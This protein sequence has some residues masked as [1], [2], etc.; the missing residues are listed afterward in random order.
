MES[1]SLAFLQALEALSPTQRAVL[2]LT[3]VFD[4]SSAEV[5]AA[6]E[7]SVS[8][9]RTIHHRAKRAM[10][11]YDKQRTIPTTDRRRATAAALE[12]FLQLLDDADMAGIEQMLAEDVRAVTDGGGEFC[13]SR[14]PIVGQARVAR[15]LVKLRESRVAFG[16][17]RIVELNGF[18]AALVEFDAPMGRR[19]PRVA[20]A[21]DLANDGH[22]T[23]LWAI[24]NSR[25]LNAIRTFGSATPRG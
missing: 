16:R 13:A 10:D 24:A 17:T 15:F 2:L 23:R 14:Q 19:P 5:A 22:I 8:N 6:L 12:R 25:K 21:L 4:Y 7:L 18:P 3:D 20:L 1:V 11:A 9:V